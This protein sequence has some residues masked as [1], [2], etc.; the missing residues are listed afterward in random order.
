MEN[1]DPI[2]SKASGPA[3]DA[4]TDLVRLL[5]RQAAQSCS[6]KIP[7]LSKKPS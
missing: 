7:N 5:A 3:S 6:K 2:T 1:H 4:L